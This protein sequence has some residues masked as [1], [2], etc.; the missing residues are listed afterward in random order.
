MFT[1]HYYED[2]QL[3]RDPI[4]YCA[5]KHASTA[6]KEARREADA[7]DAPVAVMRDDKTTYIMHPDGRAERAPASQAP[8][9]AEDCVQGV[10]DRACFCSPCRAIRRA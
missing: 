3:S 9:P 2:G 5:Y 8:S 6:R 4:G 10:E 1:L 7:T